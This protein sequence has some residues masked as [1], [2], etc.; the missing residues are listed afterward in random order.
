MQ[1][2]FSLIISSECARLRSIPRTS[3]SLKHDMLAVNHNTHRLGDCA[4]WQ[5]LQWRVCHVF[6][7]VTLRWSMSQAGATVNALKAF[8]HSS[9][10]HT[11]VGSFLMDL[12]LSDVSFSYYTVHISLC[13]QKSHMHI[14]RICLQLICW[15]LIDTSSSLR[16]MLKV[17]ESWFGSVYPIHKLSSTLCSDWW[18]F[19]KC[20][21]GLKPAAF[22]HMCA[23]WI[24]VWLLYV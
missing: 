8:P 4:V 19:A 23:V 16:G 15:R 22:W 13:V 2:W 12:C 11:F 24:I 9:V 14:L 17:F 5:I 21:M 3:L 20:E 10:H 7:R 6:R 1:W 18:P